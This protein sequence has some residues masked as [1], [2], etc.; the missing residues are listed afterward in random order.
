MTDLIKFNKIFGVILICLF[1]L[2]GVNGQAPCNTGSFLG[3]DKCGAEPLLVGTSCGAVAEDFR[4]NNCFGT[5]AG[6]SSCGLAG[7]THFVWGRFLVTVAD[8][9]TITWVASNN[10]NIRLGLYQYT[11]PCDMDFDFDYGE[12]EIT[13]VNA[14]GNGVNETIT[15]FLS[16]GTY[17]ILG[18][19]TGNLNTTSDICVY[20]PNAPALPSATIA[21]D[22]SDY[23]DV[24]TDLS[25]TIDPNGIGGVDEIPAS[26]S[27]GNPL[28]NNPGGSGN[29]GCLQDGEKN[30]TWMVV[31]VSGTGNLEF[32]FGGQGM[33]AGL[34]DWIMYPYDVNSCTDIP[35]NS[36][37]PVRCN[38]NISSF[39]GTGLADIIPSQGDVGNY[40]PSLPVVSGE[41]YIICFSNYSGVTTFVP[42]EFAGTASVS[43]TPLPVKLSNFNAELISESHYVR[44]NWSTITEVNNDYFILEKSKDGVGF[45]KVDRL[46]GAGNS[47]G[48]MNYEVVDESP[49]DGL[50]YYRLKQVDFDGKFE[51]SSIVSVTVEEKVK[52]MVYPNP[53]NQQIL[54]DGLIIGDKIELVNLMGEVVKYQKSLNEKEIIKIREILEGIYF[55]KIINNKSTLIKKII[56]QH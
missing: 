7:G 30:S 17:Y 56:I 48:L 42:L 44:T 26:G 37:A 27:T 25:F 6:S 11:D 28:G 32:V 8:N 36:I 20:S 34:Y 50:N 47:T 29:D 31:N 24:C 15:Q 10:R 2:S 14:G 49:H 13:C 55:V 51:Y 45:E 23:E 22:C 12:T 3:Y 1:I 40:E 43:C 5:P 16:I 39:G 54:I 41:Q 46:G 38:W 19:S 9:F 53:A 21:S 4:T 33:Q 35:S 52:I 18:E